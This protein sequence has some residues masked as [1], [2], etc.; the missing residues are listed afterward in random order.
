MIKVFLVQIDDSCISAFVVGVAGAA[1]LR[2][3]FSMETVF[4]TNVRADVLVA[5]HAKP[6]L[7]LS[8]EL[9]MALLALI[10]QLGVSLDQFP[11][12]DDG[13][14]TLGLRSQWSTEQ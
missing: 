1:C 10:F 6:V 4:G 9:G 3:A 14:D 7:R 2:L 13:F 8:V 5:I 12:V 11:G